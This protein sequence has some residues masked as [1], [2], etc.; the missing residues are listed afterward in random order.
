MFVKFHANGVP[1]HFFVDFFRR[2]EL[3]SVMEL[4]G[5]TTIIFEKPIGNGIDGDDNIKVD[6]S[7]DEVVKQL[8]EVL[9]H[10]RLGD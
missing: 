10:C 7:V 9:G 5:K 4:D 1:S 2:H 3:M 6:E 8:T